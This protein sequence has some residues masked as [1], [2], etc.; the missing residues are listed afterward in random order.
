MDGDSIAELGNNASTFII[1]DRETLSKQRE[2][3][4]GIVDGSI[5]N[6]T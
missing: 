3:R 6:V 4:T 5:W 2:A 1:R